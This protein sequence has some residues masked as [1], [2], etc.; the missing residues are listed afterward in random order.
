MAELARTLTRR[1]SVPLAFTHATLFDSETGKTIPNTTVL[2]EGNRIKAVGRDGS[3]RLP[4]NAE[5]VDARGK[6]LMPGLWDMHVH[7]SPDDGL[8]HIAAGVTSARDMANDTEALLALKGKIEAGEEIGPRILMAGIMDGR[9]PYAGPTKVLVDTEDEARAAVEN[10][11]RLGYA[12][13]KIYSSR[14]RT[15][16]AC[17]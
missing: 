16:R 14:W 15:R 3:V 10:Y 12:Q 8:M 9:G 7:I 17:A 2:V 4:A 11:A 6:T 5:L 1:P 13:V